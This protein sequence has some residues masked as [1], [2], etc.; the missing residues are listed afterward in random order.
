MFINQTFH[1]S[2]L[3]DKSIRFDLHWRRCP[4]MAW[5]LEFTI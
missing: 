1:N 4:L 3:V 5:N 2:L